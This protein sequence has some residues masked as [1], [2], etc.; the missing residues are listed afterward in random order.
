MSCSH[1]S[2]Y[3]HSMATGNFNPLVLNEGKK[4]RKTYCKLSE[5]ISVHNIIFC[6]MANTKNLKHCFAG[7]FFCIYISEFPP[8]SCQTF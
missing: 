5:K 2:M 8:H 7:F 4:R 1:F 6:L 3:Y